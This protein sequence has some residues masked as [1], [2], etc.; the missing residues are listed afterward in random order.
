MSACAPSGGDPTHLADNPQEPDHSPN[1]GH[2]FPPDPL[3][4]PGSF[5]DTAP[6]LIPGQPAGNG[7]QVGDERNIHGPPGDGVSSSADGMTE[8]AAAESTPSGRKGAPAADG[9]AE[10]PNWLPDGWRVLT[11]VRASGATAGSTDRYY[12]DPL[13]GFRFRSKKEVE[14]YL[15]TGTK[16]KK[17]SVTDSDGNVSEARRQSRTS[18][19]EEVSQ[20]KEGE[21]RGPEF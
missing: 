5:I 9:L 2:F 13:S 6:D 8:S 4:E 16:R 10:T 3:L 14:Y 17:A 1:D 18:Q 11:K 21:F 15:Q 12:V 20:H 7:D 19:A